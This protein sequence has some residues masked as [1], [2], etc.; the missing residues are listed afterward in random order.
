MIIISQGEFTWQQGLLVQACVN[1][2]WLL[3][4][5]IDNAP[6]D[7]V[8]YSLKFVDCGQRCKNVK[9]GAEALSDFSRILKKILMTAE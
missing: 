2:H 4:E 3:L 1:G 9:S 6:M 7:V 8:S 5:D